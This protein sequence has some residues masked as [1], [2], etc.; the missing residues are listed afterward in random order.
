MKGILLDTETG[1]LNIQVQRD[2]NGRIL[3][4]LVVGNTDFQ[5]VNLII[6]AQKGEF[7]NAPTI[8]FGIDN[9]LRSKGTIKQQFVNELQ[10]E[11]ESGGYRGARVIPGNSLL[12][13]E[14]KLRNN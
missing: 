4:G 12:E 3:S 10:K 11:L 14:V 13:F 7:K 6:Q 5:N 2:A 9:Y 8:G 1:D